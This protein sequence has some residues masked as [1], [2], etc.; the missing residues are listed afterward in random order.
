[1]FLAPFGLIKTQMFRT[2][3]DDCQTKQEQC[4]NNLGDCLVTTA[5]NP[6]PNPN[7]SD[8]CRADYRTES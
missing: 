8:Q 6:N 7:N 1:M 5:G 3:A 4:R 2:I